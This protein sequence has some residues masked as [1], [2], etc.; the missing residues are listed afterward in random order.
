MIDEN[1]VC[2]SMITLKDYEGTK[3]DLTS[4][5]ILLLLLLLL[6]LSLSLIKSK[7]CRHQRD[8]ERTLTEQSEVISS[9]F[10]LFF[11]HYGRA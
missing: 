9:P 6:L 2:A 3:I 4:R 7:L 10:A 1:A 11:P 5:K 8:T